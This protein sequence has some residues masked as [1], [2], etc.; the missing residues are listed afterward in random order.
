[1][2]LCIK[3]TQHSDTQNDAIYAMLSIQILRITILDMATL[4]IMTYHHSA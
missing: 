3:K 2:F 1:M 4:S